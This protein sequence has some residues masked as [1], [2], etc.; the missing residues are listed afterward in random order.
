MPLHPHWFIDNLPVSVLKWPQLAQWSVRPDWQF[1]VIVYRMKENPK[2]TQRHIQFANV[3]KSCY[4]HFDNCPFFTYTE[5]VYC[6]W[7]LQVRQVFWRQLQPVLVRSRSK[8][9]ISVLANIDTAWLCQQLELLS[10][11]ITYPVKL[12]EDWI[13]LSNQSSCLILSGTDP[14]S[15]SL[16]ILFIV[17]YMKYVA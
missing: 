6:T 5:H 16:R 10:N 2:G 7:L 8:D 1:T 17:N 4:L 15:I 11:L 13:N 9:A 14:G 3:T 12:E